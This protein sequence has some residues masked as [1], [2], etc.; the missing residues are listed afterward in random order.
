MDRRFFSIGKINFRPGNV[1]AKSFRQTSLLSRTQSQ[2]LR[3]VT[4]ALEENEGVG[5]LAQGVDPK[6]RRA[7]VFVVAVASLCISNARSSVCRQAH[8]FSRQC[9]HVAF[10]SELSKSEQAC[11]AMVLHRSGGALS[12]ITNQDQKVNRLERPGNNRLVLA[13]DLGGS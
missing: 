13:R 9:R 6:R 1:V 3:H 4:T 12:L 7:A 5:V 10:Q 8:N 11:C 2:I